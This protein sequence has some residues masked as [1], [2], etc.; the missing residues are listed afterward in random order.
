MAQSERSER[1][2]IQCLRNSGSI[3]AQVGHDR[4]D[5]I[6]A[7]CSPWRVHCW[8]Y[9]NAQPEAA[10]LLA[11][12]LIVLALQ[13]WIRATALPLLLGVPATNKKSDPI[14]FREQQ[15]GYALY[16]S[17]FK[18]VYVGQA[19]AND[20]RRLFDRLKDH[21]KDA[22]AD[23]WSLFSWFGT[24]WVKDDGDL[25]AVA[26]GAHTTVGAVL[27]H[28][29]AILIST[30]EPPYNRQ[31]GKFGNGVQKYLQHRDVE[32]LGLPTNDMILSLY[33]QNGMNNG[34]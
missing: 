9:A 16:D 28:I 6:G 1:I 14:N 29:E 31:G 11:E 21:R 18:L 32:E 27:N 34:K 33:Q 13:P 7:K 19:G 26:I 30:A 15:G 22:L 4:L 12:I 24:R 20:K 10:Q 3:A 25:A 17:S 8:M 23:R 5:L 2:T